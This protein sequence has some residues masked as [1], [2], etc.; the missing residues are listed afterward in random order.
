MTVGKP[1]TTLLSLAPG[2]RGGFIPAPSS[3][4]GHRREVDEKSGG[5]CLGFHYENRGFYIITLVTLEA[6]ATTQE[7]NGIIIAHV[8]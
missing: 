4:L 5:T 2:P 6:P 8:T 3:F 1:S 7:E